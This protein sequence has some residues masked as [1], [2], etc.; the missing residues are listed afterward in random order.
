[1]QNRTNLLTRDTD[2][3]SATLWEFSIFQQVSVFFGLQQCECGSNCELYLEVRISMTTFQ[4]AVPLSSAGGGNALQDKQRYH[5]TGLYRRV[6]V[7]HTV[8][9]SLTI[10]FAFTYTVTRRTVKV[11]LVSQTDCGQEPVGVEAFKISKE[12][13]FLSATAEYGFG[14]TRR[15]MRP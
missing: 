2:Q 10:C 5:F 8:G 9:R 7:T 6:G 1:M 14:N 12:T 3:K 15:Q 13:S 11:I 4:K